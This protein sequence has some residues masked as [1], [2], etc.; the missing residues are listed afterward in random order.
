M[1]TELT[2]TDPLPPGPGPEIPRADGRAARTRARAIALRA[3]GWALALALLGLNAW[4]AWRDVRPVADLPT[5]TNWIGQERLA[6]AEWALRERLRRSPHDGE[7]L[8]LLARLQAARGDMLGCGRTLRRVPFW[9][10]TRARLLFMEGQAFKSVDRMADAETAWKELSEFDPLHPMPDDL[11]A[12]AVM[13]LLEL[14]ALEERWEEARRLIWRAYD[15]AEPPDRPSL[16]VMRMRTELERIAPATSV[17]KLRRFVAAAPEDWEARRA[18]ALAEHATGND[19]EA[20]RLMQACMEERPEDPRGWRDYL[21]L[22][23]E[24]GNLDSLDQALARVPAAAADD[25]AVLRS[26]AIVQEQR[27]DWEDAAG[28]YRRLLDKEKANG[29][30]L[31]RLAAAEERLGQHESARKHRDESRVIRDARGDLNQAFQEYLEASGAE[32]PQPK[33]LAAAV[34]RLASLCET[35]GWKREAEA[36]AQ[37]APAD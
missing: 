15:R 7:A 34:G 37:L 21:K 19:R 6:E 10:P 23:H 22:L 16:L 35:L 36:W 8:A 3:G 13:E 26:R 9:W 29:E 31:F 24:Q 2:K 11:V 28:T 12:K 27:G 1:A 32:R 18:L 25:P 17:V 4:W 5:V 20:T 33:A 30:S 14:Y